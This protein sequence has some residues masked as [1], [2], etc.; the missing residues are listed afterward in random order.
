M[1]TDLCKTHET[2]LAGIG[3][4]L[5]LVAALPGCWEYLPITGATPRAVLRPDLDRKGRSMVGR[6]FGGSGGPGHRII[7]GTLP[8]YGSRPAASLGSGSSPRRTRR[9]ARG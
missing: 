8:R 6:L 2:L 7:R 3:Q 9:T 4:S 5:I 1:S